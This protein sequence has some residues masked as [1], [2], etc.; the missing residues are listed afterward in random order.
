M[1]SS[2]MIV[3]PGADPRLRQ[4][5][6]RNVASEASVASRGILAACSILALIRAVEFETAPIRIQ[7]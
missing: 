1:P 3:E 2:K 7:D 6:L 5:V 4:S